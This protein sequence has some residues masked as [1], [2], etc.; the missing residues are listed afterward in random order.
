M[1]KFTAFSLIMTGFFVFAWSRAVLRY[2]ERVMSLRA[3]ILW[4]VVWGL[5]T[6]FTFLPNKADFLAHFLGVSDGKDAVFSFSIVI[7]F[8][9]IYRIYAALDKLGRKIDLINQRASIHLH[10]VAKS[11]NGSR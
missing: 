3:L 2:R 11:K 7:I 5:A 9:S 1:I 8:Y 10:S 4:T 6:Y